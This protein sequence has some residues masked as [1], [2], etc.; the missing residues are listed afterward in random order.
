MGR[1]A[2]V[3]REVSVALASAAVA[4]V[5]AGCVEPDGNS[6]PAPEQDRPG[7]AEQVIDAGGAI[8]LEP[9]AGV[10]VAVAY[11]GD[12][13][14]QLTTACDTAQTGEACRFD[15]LITGDESGSALSDPEGV[16]LESEDELFAPDPLALEMAFVTEDDL[17]GATFSAEPGASLRVGV[18]LYDPQ[19][20]SGF[21]WTDD[22]RLLSWVGNGGV[23]WGAPSNPVDLT[24][25]QP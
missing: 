9:G 13:R 24:P 23:N 11:A 7:V 25:D 18:L 15:I 5:A 2:R 6:G 1:S 8:E 14:W 4:L 19:L 16:E 20:D 10:G 17:D 3:A 21:D 22:P 12:G